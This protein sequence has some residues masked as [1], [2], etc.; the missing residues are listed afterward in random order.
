M[1]R[2]IRREKVVGSPIAASNG[3]TVTAWAPP[4]AAPKQA[5][6]VRS[7]FTH[8]SRRVIIGSD[9]TACCTWPR[10]GRR[11]AGQLGDAGPQPAG[12]P[13]LGDRQELV[14]RCGVT[15]LELPAGDLGGEAALLQRPQVG[16]AGGEGA[17]RAPGRPSLRPRGRAGRRRSSPAPGGGRP[18][19]GETSGSTRTGRRCAGAGL[20]GQRV[21][22]EVARRGGRVREPVAPQRPSAARPRRR[23]PAPASSTTGARSSSTSASTSGRSPAAM[24]PAPTASHSEVTPFSRSVSTAC[25]VAVASGSAKCWRT[26][27]PCLAPAG[28]PAAPDVRR[29]AGEAAVRRRVVGG[30]ERTDAHPVVRRG[31]QHG[32]GRRRVGRLREAAGPAQDRAHEAPPLLGGRRGEAL[33]QRQRERRSRPARSTVSPRGGPGSRAAAGGAAASPGGS[34]R[35]RAG[36]GGVA[37]TGTL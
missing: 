9:V 33:G 35:G 4:V 34:G 19:A 7:M 5:R 17:A 29:D 18:G 36:P 3:R 30:V 21:Q 12:G 22:A 32:L 26:S 13:Q 27:Q 37:R 8:G 31:A 15:E 10:V 14:R 2:A 24:P 16:D 1:L 6:V 23:C 11:H 20:H 25:R 28:R